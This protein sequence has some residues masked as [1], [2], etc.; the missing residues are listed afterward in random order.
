MIMRSLPLFSVSMLVFALT[1]ILPLPVLYALKIPLRPMIIPPVGKSGPVIAVIN[2]LTETSGFSINIC[3][4]EIISERLCGG[5][6]VV[7][8]TAIPLTPLTNN[9]GTLAGKT[10]GSFSLSS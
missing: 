7:I 4:P 9:A 2:S 10:T 6:L 8:P 3:N 5:I 1:T